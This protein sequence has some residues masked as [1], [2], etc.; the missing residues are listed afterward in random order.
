MSGQDAF[1]PEEWARI[2]A[3]PMLVGMAVTA[4]DPGGLFS[5]FQ[6][7]AAVAGAIAEGRDAGN[8]LI[9]A[10]S[11]G[12]ASPDNRAALMESIRTAIGPATAPADVVAA[13]ET[14]LGRIAGIV[15]A[16]AE[17][18]APAFADWLLGIARSVA[19]AG[20]EGGFLGF[21]GVAVSAAETAT[22]ERL[23]QT[24]TA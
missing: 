7:S 13:C 15:R 21:G 8:G 3:S 14:E 18:D 10:V 5:A 20:K 9:A 1:T 11:G 22:L 16:K 24:L 17:P 23:R 4:A 12:Y 19:E 6:E 2:I